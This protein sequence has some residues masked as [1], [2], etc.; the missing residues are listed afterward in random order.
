MKRNNE[1]QGVESK[2]NRF[3]EGIF[4]FIG[5]HVGGVAFIDVLVIAHCPCEIGKMLQN[6]L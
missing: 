3:F 1:R 4:F 5:F 2:V 6:S